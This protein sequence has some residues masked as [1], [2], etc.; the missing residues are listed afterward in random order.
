LGDQRKKDGNEG[1]LGSEIGGGACCRAVPDHVLARA[2]IYS[3]KIAQRFRRL[4]RPFLPL[5]LAATALRGRRV[6]HHGIASRQIE[7]Q[8]LGGV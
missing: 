3:E 8:H 7:H 6:A 1:H 2:L 4:T 5:R